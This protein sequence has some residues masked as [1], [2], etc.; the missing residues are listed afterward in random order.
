MVAI[1]GRPQDVDPLH[2]W[3]SSF[4]S[5]SVAEGGGGNRDGCVS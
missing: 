4:F 2:A 5:M 1:H 3:F